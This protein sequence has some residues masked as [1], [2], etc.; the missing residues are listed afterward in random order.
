MMSIAF[1]EDGLNKT[2]FT[3][4]EWEL[5][6]AISGSMVGGVVGVWQGWMILFDLAVGGAVPEMGLMQWFTIGFA[7]LGTIL[8]CILGTVFG[9]FWAEGKERWVSKGVVL[10]YPLVV[11]VSIG[12]LTILTTGMATY[13]IFYR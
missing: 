2:E 6:G 10:G 12:L 3:V 8:G 11:K 4:R 1:K 9:K 7:V 13:F 5:F